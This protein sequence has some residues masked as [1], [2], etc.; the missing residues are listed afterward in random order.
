[1]NDNKDKKWKIL[2]RGFDTKIQNGLIVL[3]WTLLENG[4]VP[5]ASVKW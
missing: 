3:E 1:M 2:I 4:S 5:L